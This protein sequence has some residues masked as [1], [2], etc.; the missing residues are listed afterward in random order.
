MMSV[1]ICEWT[2]VVDRTIAKVMSICLNKYAK[3]NN[4]KI[5]VLSCHKDIID[6]LEPDWVFDTDSKQF[7]KNELDCKTA[8]KVAKIEIFTTHD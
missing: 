6:W 5:I 3:K 1:V 8:R 7:S 4:K 2:S